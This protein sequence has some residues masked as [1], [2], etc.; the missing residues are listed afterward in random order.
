MGA[1]PSSSKSNSTVKKSSNVDTNNKSNVAT[2]NNPNDN[3]T[4]VSLRPDYHVMPWQ[5][6]RYQYNLK[7]LIIIVKAFLRFQEKVEEMQ[8]EY[9]KAAEL[10]NERRLAKKR[11][12]LEKSKELL[13]L[14]NNQKNHWLFI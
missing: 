3:I 8:A 13:R 14:I 11:L 1:W 4:T 12:L 5:L 7:I 6:N 10:L 9:L 2:T